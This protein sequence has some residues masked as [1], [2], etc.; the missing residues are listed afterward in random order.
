MLLRAGAQVSDAFRQRPSSIAVWLAAKSLGGAL[1]LIFFRTHYPA[2]GNPYGRAYLH[3]V[4]RAGGFGTYKDVR[5]RECVAA[6]I[7]AR[8]RR[9][10]AEILDVTLNFLLDR[11]SIHLVIQKK[12]TL[13]HISNE[14]PSTARDDGFLSPRC[15]G[16]MR[17]NTAWP[18]RGS[19]CYRPPGSTL[20][21]DREST[22][23]SACLTRR[24]IATISPGPSLQ[25]SSSKPTTLQA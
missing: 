14:R 4:A 11:G 13:S 21:L 16:L 2:L 3:N 9:L 23:R 20:W 17:L 25:G 15:S 24:K 12:N 18:A 22:V 8:E 5:Y 6:H 19:R 1:L 7:A 10:P